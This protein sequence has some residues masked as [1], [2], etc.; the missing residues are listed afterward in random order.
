MKKLKTF[1]RFW[2][3][4]RPDREEDFIY[5]Y[6]EVPLN[7]LDYDADRQCY[8][9][10]PMKAK[11]VE[12]LV[13]VKMFFEPSVPA[14][15]NVTM[16]TFSHTERYVVKPAEEILRILVRDGY[17]PD[18][19]GTFIHPSINRVS[20]TNDMWACCGERVIYAGDVEEGEDGTE[21]EETFMDVD[22]LYEFD[23][24]WVVKVEGEDSE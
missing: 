8:A 2:V 13:D 23:P 20:F 12:E 1:G 17:V 7:T 18:R 4:E 22:C 16:D 14:V 11:S 19:E 21:M 15:E 9:N 3:R 6:V 5:G 10:V 24:A